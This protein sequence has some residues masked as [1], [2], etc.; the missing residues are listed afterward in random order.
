MNENPVHWRPYIAAD[1]R[2]EVLKIYGLS[3][4]IRY[5]WPEPKVHAALETLL[6][7]IDSAQRSSRTCLAIRRPDAARRSAGPL[8]ERIIQAKVGAVVERYRRACASPAGG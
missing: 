1:E 2:Q 6:S 8:S 5:Y 7:N 4:R 3:D